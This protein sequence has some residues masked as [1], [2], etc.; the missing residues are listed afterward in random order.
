MSSTQIALLGAIAGITI[1]IGL[2]VGRIR[3]LK[4]STS[5]LLNAASAGV[6]LF[7]L[8]ET[9]VHG[10]EPVEEALFDV[11]T[12]TSGT[13]GEFVVRT[14]LFFGAFALGLMG[15]VG[16]DRQMARRRK[17]SLGPGAAAVQEF[18]TLR[19]F[20]A[21]SDTKRLS[22]LIA[23]GIGVHNLAEGLAI[24]QI[25][26]S[27]QLSLAV[28]LVVGFA[29]HNATEGFGIVAPLAGETDRPSWGFLFVLGVI[30]GLPT[31]LGTII[32]QSFVNENL[33]LLFLGLAAGSI[34]YVVVTLVGVAIKHGHKEMLYVGL[35]AGVT[36]GALTE[37]VLV[38]GGL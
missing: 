29:L 20:H 11:T 15:L 37:L 30:A 7:L 25:A 23:V 16:Y 28:L 26:A 8:I 13:W 36:L 35:F 14:V 34:L 1:F 12:K 9:F 33:E 10:F 27:D 21:L 38:A 6:L 24:G 2:P 22:V 31:F 4:V 18:G 17:S 32:G 19:K 3:K 5:T